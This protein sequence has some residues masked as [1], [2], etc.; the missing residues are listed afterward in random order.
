[1]AENFKVGILYFLKTKGE[2]IMKKLLMAICSMVMVFS[3]FGFKVQAAETNVDKVNQ[4]IEKTNK[5]I[6]FE[7]QKAVTQANM[8]VFRYNCEKALFAGEIDVNYTNANIDRLNNVINVLNMEKNLQV[9]N[10]GSKEYSELQKNVED[11][12]TKVNSKSETLF[13]AQKQEA[14]NKITLRFNNDLDKIINHLIDVT[15]Q[16]AAKLIEEAKKYGVEVYSEWIEVE[17]GG[18]VVLVDP[19]KSRSF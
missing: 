5:E 4:M 10:V 12:V 2:C 9:L 16:K 13:S 1:M 11:V 8:L 19:C 14:L 18:R 15:N 3:F 17:I 7:I 6:D